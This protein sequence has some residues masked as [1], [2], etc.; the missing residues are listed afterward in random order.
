MCSDRRRV[1]LHIAQRS[2]TTGRNPKLATLYLFNVS[3]R[4][5]FLWIGLI[6]SRKY[7]LESI[8]I[9]SLSDP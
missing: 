4:S 7:C 2:L 6:D 5:R 9:A 8:Q 3:F 1:F